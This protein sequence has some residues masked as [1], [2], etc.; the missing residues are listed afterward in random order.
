MVAE[1]AGKEL[2]DSPGGGGIAAS[3]ASWP[4]SGTLAPCGFR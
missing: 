4:R 2:I 1:S 3:A